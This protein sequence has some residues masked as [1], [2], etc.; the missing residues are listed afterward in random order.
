MYT[1]TNITAT[2][3]GI[4]I[5]SPLLDLR[6]GIKSQ[7]SLIRKRRFKY[8]RV[9]SLIQQ[10]ELVNVIYV[11]PTKVNYVSTWLYTVIDINRFRIVE[12]DK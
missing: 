3:N 11:R 8:C 5:L 12:T 9:L 2:L 1:N 4:F 7:I 6:F 10:A